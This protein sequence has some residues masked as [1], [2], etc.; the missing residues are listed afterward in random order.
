[1]LLAVEEERK[2]MNLFRKEL[3]AQAPFGYLTLHRTLKRKKTEE[4]IRPS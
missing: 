4:W 3:E 1:M 2:M